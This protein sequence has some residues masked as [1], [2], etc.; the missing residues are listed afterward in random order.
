MSSIKKRIRK[1]T[2]KY[3]MEIPT[4]IEHA[5]QIDSKNKNHFWRN[6]IQKEMTNIGVAFEI[7]S[8]GKK[9][10]PGW[11]GASRRLVFDVKMDFTRN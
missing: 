6:T 9:A 3:G 2:H 8:T 4:S 1:T 5:Y 10:P 11:K 7:L